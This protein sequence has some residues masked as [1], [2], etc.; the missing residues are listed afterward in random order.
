MLNIYRKLRGSFL[1]VI[2]K[3]RLFGQF[4]SLAIACAELIL[5]FSVF[6]FHG[7]HDL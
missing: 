4:T 1:Y 3:T 6:L 2:E 7:N 5:F